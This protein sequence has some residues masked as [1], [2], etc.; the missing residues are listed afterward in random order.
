MAQL[1]YIVQY[2]FLSLI[3]NTSFFKKC[4]LIL[5]KYLGRMNSFSFNAHF[6]LILRACVTFYAYKFYDIVATLDFV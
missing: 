4:Y 2:N 5:L 1:S 3:S 6:L